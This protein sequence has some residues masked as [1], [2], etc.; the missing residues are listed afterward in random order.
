MCAVYLYNVRVT[1]YF[2]NDKE[3]YHFVHISKNGGTSIEQLNDVPYFHFYNHDINAGKINADKIYAV[4]RDPISRFVSAFYF[5]K[6][7]GF[8]P[9]SPTF[10]D[11]PIHNYDTA[12]DFI[13]ELKKHNTIAI[14]TLY[15]TQEGT[16]GTDSNVIYWTQ[17]FWLYSE[18]NKKLV[19]LDFA[20]LNTNF[21]KLTG[22]DLKYENVTSKKEKLTDENINF[23]KK[24]YE[25]DFKLYEYVRKYQIFNTDTDFVKN[26]GNPDKL[27]TPLKLQEKYLT[28]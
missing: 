25:P 13:N 18:I 3:E 28:Q 10:N 4:I 8:D 14:N 15:S 5:A 2:T 22:K 21:K 11:H 19:L 9:N 7:G 27:V 6:K 23:L 24:L 17:L 1:N 16:D 12:N 20:N 26:L